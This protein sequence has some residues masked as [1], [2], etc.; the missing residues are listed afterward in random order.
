MNIIK[1]LILILILFSINQIQA[2]KF[3]GVASILGVYDGHVNK[4]SLLKNGKIDII[5][6]E[7]RFH[8]IE[9]TMIIYT[10]KYPKGRKEIKGYTLNFSKDIKQHIDSV[11][12]MQQI[13]FTDIIIQLKDSN[14]VQLN[15]IIIQ[16]GSKTKPEIYPFDLSLRANIKGLIEGKIKKETLLI[17][18]TVF[19]NNQDYKIV[20][21]QLAH[22]NLK[23][24]YE[25]SRRNDC[26]FNLNQKG[27]IKRSIVGD[28]L[29]IKNIIVQNS[30]NETFKIP[31]LS[32]IFTE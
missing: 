31:P 12:R 15:P 28:R 1:Y 27:M 8:L 26:T 29:F 3:E 7:S 17:C 22:P 2:Q 14:R 9:F 16:L 11:S 23:W 19:T 24:Y 5:T 6:K 13:F 20:E 21:F 4:D 18:D 10:W 25:L 32:I 30:N